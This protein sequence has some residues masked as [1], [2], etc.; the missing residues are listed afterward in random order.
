MCLLVLSVMNIEVLLNLRFFRWFFCL[1]EIDG[2]E[3]IVSGDDFDWDYWIT[4][5]EYFLID[6]SWKFDFKFVAFGCYLK[7]TG[8]GIAR[9]C[10]LCVFKSEF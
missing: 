4:F 6:L 3:L 5:L 2:F 9:K 8:F 10:R 1:F 7:I